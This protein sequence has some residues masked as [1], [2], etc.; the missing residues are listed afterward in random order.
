MI[1][2]AGAGPLPIPNK[3]LTADK[4]AA[5]IAKC[6]EPGTLRRAQD[7]GAKIGFEEGTTVG[8]ESFHDKL[9]V[10]S[11]RCDIVPSYVA[12]WQLKRTS[13]KLSA[14]AVATLIEEGLLDANDLKL[15]RPREYDSED[16]PWDPI[17]G[18]LGA[19]MGTTGN[20]M[21][22]VA[23][24][25]A[26]MFKGLRTKSSGQDQAKESNQKVVESINSLVPYH[27]SDEAK[28]YRILHTATRMPPRL[29]TTAGID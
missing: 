3:E 28:V 25:P 14:F 7:L 19:L 26:G 6:L 10:D 21:M 29:E 22:G 8:A 1:A 9:E 15:Y 4:L 27:T 13:I 17:S 24:Y 5:G 2:R 23:D 20:L 16:A 11:L 12:V 18:I